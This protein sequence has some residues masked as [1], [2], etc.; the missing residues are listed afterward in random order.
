MAAPNSQQLPEGFGEWD[1]LK[2]MEFA[3]MAAPTA[4]DVAEV[5][6]M[7]GATP[8]QTAAFAGPMFENVMQVLSR[9]TE[10]LGLRP[11]PGDVDDIH[12]TAI[13]ADAHGLSIRFFPG[14]TA[15]ASLGYYFMD[16]YDL[17]TRE[18]AQTPAGY[19]F[20]QHNQHG[21]LE[22]SGRVRSMEEAMGYAPGDT[23]RFSVSEGTVCELRRPECEPF[24]F[25]APVRN[26]H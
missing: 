14:G 5:L 4:E 3:G 16:L 13:P 17:S 8:E 23:E 21:S 10:I 7:F 19:A 20:Y 18:P 22:P 9:P 6:K 25:S 15:A 12:V 1:G 26:S 24:F 2:Q 11:Q